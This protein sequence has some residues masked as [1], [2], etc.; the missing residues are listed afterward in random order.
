MCHYTVVCSANTECMLLCACRVEPLRTVTLYSTVTTAVTTKQVEG[1]GVV[2]AN[3][4]APYAE[5][6]WFESWPTDGLSYVRGLKQTSNLPAEFGV[7][8]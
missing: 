5:G 8:P 2:L 1:R 6:I 4:N 7:G 3:T